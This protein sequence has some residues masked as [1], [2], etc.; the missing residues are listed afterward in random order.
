MACLAAGCL[1]QRCSTNVTIYPI[2]NPALY[3]GSDIYSFRYHLSNIHPNP[4]VY[5]DTD[6]FAN[7]S[8][9]PRTQKN[10]KTRTRDDFGDFLFSR[11]PGDRIR[12]RQYVALV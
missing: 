6:L 3:F 8:S 4:I 9:H 12:H 5:N 2:A 10:W 1:L 7:R 11:R